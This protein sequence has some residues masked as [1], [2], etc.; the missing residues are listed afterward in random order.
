MQKTKQP[1]RLEPIKRGTWAYTVKRLKESWQWYVLLLPA[2]IYLIIF[3][4][5][6]MYGI[7]IAF[8][9]YKPSKG[10]LGSP[11]VGFKHFIRFFKYPYFW[12]MIENTLNITL[13]S[14]CTFPC[15]IIFALFLNEVTHTKYKKFAQ[16]VSYMPHFLSEVVVVSLVLLMLDLDHGP[17]N[18][19]IKLFGGEPYYFMGDNDAFPLIY[20]L[21]GLWQG[22]GWGAILYISALSSVPPEQIEA[23]R[24]DGASR[25]QTMWHINLPTILPTIMITFIMRMGSVFSLGYTKIL[26]F[27]QNSPL[28]NEA[29]N[30][31]SIYTYQAGIVG[32]QFSYTTAIG[33]FNNLLNITLLLI[34]NKLSKK[35]TETG[36]F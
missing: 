16:M 29:T 10:I 20:V 28:I 4:Y 35:V 2:L 6:P 13:L 27:R 32:G 30:I 7:L 8:K 26:L 1:V 11:W 34:F 3:E 33:L 31:I 5:G 15:S 21:Q 25:A 12:E 36:L 23:A 17:I 18:A 14:L 24:I 9:N 22:L 19:L